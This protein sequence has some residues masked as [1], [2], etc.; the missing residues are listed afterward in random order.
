MIKE[1]KVH[2]TKRKSSVGGTRP[3]EGPKGEQVK[4]G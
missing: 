3:K 2:C 1:G 4:E